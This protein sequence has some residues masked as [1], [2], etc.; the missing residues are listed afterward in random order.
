MKQK[1]P[2]KRLKHI[3]LCSTFNAIHL[4]LEWFKQYL[5]LVVNAFNQIN[6]LWLHNPSMKYYGA[7][8]KSLSLFTYFNKRI[9]NAK[10]TLY[11]FFALKF[12][13]NLSQTFINWTLIKFLFILSSILERIDSNLSY[14]LKPGANQ[15][16]YSLF[17]NISV[18]SR[19]IL[20][21]LN[22]TKP[23]KEW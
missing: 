17:Q 8:F 16:K 13:Q 9:A 12:S 14:V 4:M 15:I 20:L 19:F 18:A 21:N 22:P 23:K 2:H 7:S 5:K 10:K 1:L 3:C 11:S 6:L